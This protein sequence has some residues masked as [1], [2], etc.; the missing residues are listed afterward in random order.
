MERSPSLILNLEVSPGL[1]PS[2]YWWWDLQ[3]GHLVWRFHQHSP[4]CH[5]DLLQHQL[6]PGDQQPRG[7]LQ[8]GDWVR[9]G[10]EE[11]GRGL[12]VLQGP[13]QWSDQENYKFLVL[14]QRFWLQCFCTQFGEHPEERATND[15]IS[16]KLTGVT[17]LNEIYAAIKEKVIFLSFLFHTKNVQSDTGSRIK[18]V[19]KHILFW[20]GAQAGAHQD[21]HEPGDGNQQIALDFIFNYT[22]SW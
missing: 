19:F 13:G 6:P 15:E 18:L 5:P 4:H 11:E 3:A 1:P 21:P 7:D 10:G 22:C 2:S 16:E 14:Q 20:T 12:Q 8:D 17:T 9:R